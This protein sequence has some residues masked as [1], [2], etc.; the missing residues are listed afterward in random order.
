MNAYRIFFF[1]LFVF[2]A[3]NIKV[4]AQY[5]SQFDNRGF[6]QWTTR[7]S[8]PAHWHSGGTAT[9]TF[10]GFVSS[11][12]ESSTHTRPGSTGSKSVRLFPESIL[13]VTANGNLTNGRMNAGSMSATGTGN[14]NYTQRS[15]EAFNTPI[16]IMPD[17]IT[18]WVCFR[19]ESSTQYANLHAAVHGDTDYKFL[20]NGTEEPS[21]HLV[22]SARC[23]FRRTSTAG[24]DYHWTRLCIPFIKDG[25][26]NDPRYILLTLT[27]NAVPGEG[28]TNDD[29]F[30]DDILLVYNPL[31]RMSQIASNQYHNGESLTIPFTL[32]GT[33]S[34]DNL[35]DAPNEVIAQL[36]DA[37]GNFNSPI[38]LG[39]METNV[40]GSIDAVIPDVA[41]GSQYK[42][43]VVSTNYPMIG[44]NIQEIS[45]INTT[46]TEERLMLC[47][48]FPN[49]VVST[50]HLSCEQTPTAIQ[51]FDL[52]GQLLYETQLNTLD[53]NELPTGIYLLQ[54]DFGS[55]KALRRIVKL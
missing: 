12:I 14:Y 10:S 16:A 22:G 33:M 36:S 43:R 8:E 2:S 45:I 9:G 40:S 28:S 20:A 13:G 26:S 1:I 32:T 30:A 15:N 52:T 38:E 49:P 41:S 39:R 48:I 25:P 3:L 55:W 4:F 44:E 29:L 18:L 37:N 51:L 42:I 53:L 6:E 11:Q 47:D 17:S 5:G 27:T 54:V 7:V 34:A 21:S 46:N 24:G 35:N 23:D 19:S 31:L 50:L